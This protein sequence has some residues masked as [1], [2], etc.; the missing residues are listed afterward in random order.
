MGI[1][2]KM[3]KKLKRVHEKLGLDGGK[4]FAERASY[5][6]VG[7]GKVNAEEWLDRGLEIA[8]VCDYCGKEASHLETGGIFGDSEADAVKVNFEDGSSSP[9]LVHIDC[10]DD[11][12]KKMRKIE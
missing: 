10:M 5:V 1:S 2:K 12:D 9:V 6:S 4:G 8:G 11:W 3:R 7:K